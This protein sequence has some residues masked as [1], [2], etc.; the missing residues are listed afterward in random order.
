[1]STKTLEQLKAENADEV[2]VT[3]VLTPE[4]EVIEAE[5]VA[6]VITEETEEAGESV[7]VEAGEETVEA[8]MQTGGETLEGEQKKGPSFKGLKQK[9][10]AKIDAKDDELSSLRAEIEALKQGGVV[11]PKTE[12]PARPKRDDFAYDDSDAY[13]DAVDAWNDAKLDARLASHAQKQNQQQSVSSE[14][15]SIEKSVDQHYERATQLVADGKIT[16][17]AYRAADSAVRNAIE[18]VRPSQGDTISDYLIARLNSAGGG[19][20]KVWFHIGNNAEALA[21]LTSKL[22][23]DP[24]GIDASMYLGSLMNKITASPAKRVSQAPAPGT[25]LK[26]DARQSISVN[27]LLKKYK[28][29]D[30]DVQARIDIKR[31]ARDAGVDTKSWS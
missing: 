23:G 25:T 22:A 4:N 27:A 24:A 18:S 12:Q 10:R 15:A 16:E 8:W 14:Q 1:M 6:E 20:E 9:M 2:E 11:Q 29:A 5:V 26:G 21:T 19:S 7:E 3:E 31:A 28:A 17:E 13:D 30:G